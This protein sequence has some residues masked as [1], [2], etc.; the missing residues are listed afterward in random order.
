[1]TRARW[2][3]RIVS[4]V[5][6]PAVIAIRRDH[7][8][9]RKSLAAA[10]VLLVGG[11]TV[12]AGCSPAGRTNSAVYL[13]DGKPTVVV[14][15]CSSKD[16]LTG[17][18]LREDYQQ[19]SPS[20]SGQSQS[21]VQQRFVAWI[22]GASASD[23]SQPGEIQLL[24]TPP[25]WAL[26]TNPESVLS[27]LRDGRRYRVFVEYRG[28]SSGE[29]VGVVF[30]LGDL[31]SLAPG[32]VWARSKPNSQETPMTLDAFRRAAKASC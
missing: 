10:L 28:P 27:E 23:A 20:G 19:P 3:G 22:V 18:N 7:E 12:L 5:A 14:H 31:R 32:H 29:D 8:S 26:Y 25:G 21:A 1:M 9:A 15:L 11:T 30:T 24:E 17:L 13:R 6:S 4:V 2:L 16:R